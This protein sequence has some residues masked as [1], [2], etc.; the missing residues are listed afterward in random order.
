MLFKN[1]LIQITILICVVSITIAQPNS[2]VE[3]IGSCA[4]DFTD[5]ISP[6]YR[7]GLVYAS[8]ERNAPGRNCDFVIYDVADPNRFR[9][10]SKMPF[11]DDYEIR[12]IV[13]L[14]DLAIVTTWPNS[15]RIIDVADPENVEII[16]IAPGL[17]PSGV[18]TPVVKDSL[19]FFPD[20]GGN[21]RFGYV[22]VT[23]LTAE[24]SIEILTTLR[25][26]AVPTGLSIYGNRLAVALWDNDAN[27]G[28]DDK[29]ILF[30][31]S[32]T[33]SIRQEGYFE[34]KP[35]PGLN[36]AIGF[37]RVTLGDDFFVSFS[38]DDYQIVD[39]RNPASPRLR[40]IYGGTYR[41]QVDVFLDG[42][43][44]WLSGI[45]HFGVI[46][47]ADA[48][49]PRIQNVH[50]VQN[51]NPHVLAKEG[52]RFLLS[53]G[54]PYVSDGIS[55]QDLSDPNEPS[56]INHYSREGIADKISLH[57]SIAAIGFSNGFSLI[58]VSNPASPQELS[59]ENIS[60]LEALHF[61]SNGE[62]IAHS[63]VK[64]LIAFN[65]DNP[66]FPEEIASISLD[67]ADFLS[68][69]NEDV[70]YFTGTDYRTGEEGIFCYDVSEGNNMRR[71]G[72]LAGEFGHHIWYFN[73]RVIGWG[74]T[75][76]YCAGVSDPTNPLNFGI[77]EFVNG[78][79][80]QTG[81]G[82]FVLGY[83]TNRNQ[84]L[85]VVQAQF[86]EDNRLVKIPRQSF[87]PLGD[88]L[89]SITIA[90]DGRTFVAS[91]QSGVSVYSVEWG[92][93]PQLTGFYDTPGNATVAVYGPV[94]EE[95][96]LLYATDGTSFMVLEA[97]QALSA[98]L[99]PAQ[100]PTNIAL[101][102]FPNPFNSSVTI[103]FGLDKSAPTRLA[104][105][106][107][108]GRLVVDLTNSEFRTPHSVFGKVVWDAGNHPAGLYIVKLQHDKFTTT[109]K[110]VLL[111]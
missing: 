30:D 103:E 111:K 97:G 93:R 8:A 85:W 100:M 32:N 37:D 13:L 27:D 12:E 75:R 3:L 51:S 74:A 10:I 89:S 99:E 96:S 106:D 66:E 29:V 18:C 64:R 102:A 1:F 44:A 59:Y 101:S 2:D 69:Y 68:A 108:S 26:R 43:I 57:G 36:I 90:P 70:Y 52:N 40:L 76:L 71:V 16:G 92:N 55:L 84:E 98:N 86:D 31:I 35:F 82:D 104:I 91:N 9:L 81:F 14:G 87:R 95:S 11:A 19:I 45:G 72:H 79:Y 50:F 56:V 54:F 49:D 15:V 63:R 21:D 80:P 17:T 23:R 65:I 6:I 46:E 83:E 38:N 5:L 28:D 107:I 48:R 67:S 61:N 39:I 7:D 24:R 47:V 22:N 58:D 94:N 25:F 53:H 42:D 73:E 62:L 109:Q 77:S 110:I 4:F 78:F 41:Q 105:F 34:Y 60:D 33:D 20:G 88:E